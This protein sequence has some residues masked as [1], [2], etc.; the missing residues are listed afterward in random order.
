MGAGAF[1][2][3]LRRKLF[4]FAAFQHYGST[5][6]FSVRKPFLAQCMKLSKF[7]TISMF[8]AGTL[9]ESMKAACTLEMMINLSK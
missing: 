8:S 9:M 2:K 1:I 4:H 5:R 3:H 7:F 6:F